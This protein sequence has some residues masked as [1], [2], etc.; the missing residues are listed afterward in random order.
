MSEVAYTINAA[1][2]DR[3]GEV[4]KIMKATPRHLNMN[5]V[6]GQVWREIDAMVVNPD[7]VPPLE[8]LR[9]HPEFKRP[10]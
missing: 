6:S 9:R 4:V 1:I 10:R 2:F 5:I 7:H 8:T 3:K